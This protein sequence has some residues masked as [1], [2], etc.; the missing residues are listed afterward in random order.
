MK[1]SFLLSSTLTGIILSSFAAHANPPRKTTGGVPQTSEANAAPAF[2]A[3]KLLCSLTFGETKSVHIGTNTVAT[4]PLKEYQ[5][6]EKQA[7]KMVKSIVDGVV[8]TLS[9][10]TEI[11]LDQMIERQA[12]LAMRDLHDA[13]QRVAKHVESNRIIKLSV[14]QYEKMND[15]AN[16]DKEIEGSLQSFIDYLQEMNALV[17][18]KIKVATGVKGLLQN[19]PFV[20]N[21]PKVKSF[22]QD[23][24]KR[25][26]TVQDQISAAYKSI[27]KMVELLQSDNAALQDL[28]RSETSY[29]AEMQTKIVRY[30]IALEFLRETSATIQAGKQAIDPRF[31]RLL[32][33]VIIPHFAKELNTSGII[34][35]ATSN[36]QNAI[37]QQMDTNRILMKTSSDIIS[38]TGPAMA[39]AMSL[40]IAANRARS[41]AQIAKNA[42]KVTAHSLKQAASSMHESQ[43]LAQELES[44]PI[45]EASTLLEVRAILSIAQKEQ[46]AYESRRGEIFAKQNEEMAK[47]LELQ[48][49]DSKDT[50]LINKQV[51]LII[52]EQAR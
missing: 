43:K 27:G 4:L 14:Y 38:V 49:Q 3:E 12:D 40:D 42:K 29:L 30:I 34:Y 25:I 19:I 6:Q 5:E 44:A 50:N 21:I 37:R 9:S 16:V 51:Q 39:A 13:T 24:D 22:A 48:G 33:D 11:D 28:N 20:S 2:N 23:V 15:R 1:K 32:D 52:Q 7:A 10:K 31:G 18:K 36:S 8:K 47:L 35:I 17:G 26:I 46:K 45:I 41:T